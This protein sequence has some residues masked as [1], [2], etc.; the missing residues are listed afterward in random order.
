[1]KA[2]QRLLELIYFFETNPKT[3]IKDIES[4]LN[5][6]ESAVRYEIDNLNYYLRMM[7]LPEIQKENNGQLISTVVNFEPVNQLLEE[8][9]RPDSKKRRDYLTFKLVLAGKINI[10]KES[11]FLDVTRNTVK[12]DLRSVIQVLERERIYVK[13]RKIIAGNEL[14]M[15]RFILNRYRENYLVLFSEKEKRLISNPIERRILEDLEDID[16]GKM[17]AQIKELAKNYPFTNFYETF[18]L[19]VLVTI[20]RNHYGHSIQEVQNVSQIQ[21]LGE[22]IAIRKLMQSIGGSYN[23][24]EREIAYL[25]EILVSYSEESINQSY[26]KNLLSFKLFV[27]KLVTSVGKELGMELTEDPILMEGLYQH[28]KS[29]IYRKNNSYEMDSE[30]YQQAIGNYQSLFS[31]LEKNI[32]FYQNELNVHFTKEDIALFVIH[33][34][35]GIRRFQE[36][37]Q[38]NLRV[39]LVCHSGY[40]TS[41][42][43]KNLIEKN[44]NVEVI[45]TSSIYQIN[46]YLSQNIDLIV[47]TLYF[48]FEIKKT[49]EVPIL[50]I[51]PFLTFNDD[52]KLKEFGITRKREKNKISVNKLLKV[53]E[54]HTTIS[55]S[56]SLKKDLL[57]A[58]PENLQEER[59]E[60]SLFDGLKDEDITFV[61][62]IED[63]QT[64]LSMCCQSLEQNQVVKKSYLEG[65]SQSVNL[66]GAHFVIRNQIAIPHGSEKSGVLKSGIHILY[67]KNPVIFPNELPVRLIFFIASKEKELLINT[68]MTINAI[69]HDKKFYQKLDHAIEKAESLS[70][71]F[72][73]WLDGV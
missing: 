56:L 9:Y 23:F 1:M 12:S 60:S 29:T 51:S 31:L 48:S 66:Y 14:E 54:R 63:W 28:V 61:Q 22:Y 15:R 13:E 52:Q 50:F 72:K 44:Y 8:I 38:P 68:V 59:K 2:N 6:P 33:F 49:V 24:S 55:N 37:H 5:I 47:S 65:I 36:T 46:D 30:I 21:A 32:E 73:E 39:L 42:L 67:V 58:F 20:H 18:L 26:Q 10:Q 7:E 17:A 70:D 57:A 16:F 45:G 41:V 62:E 71:F 34:L 19:N 64:G 4:Q 69:S 11:I 3:S 25:T 53:L 43:L 40:G 35:G 27:S